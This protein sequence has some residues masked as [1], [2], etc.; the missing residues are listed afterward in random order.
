MS[1]QR[2]IE[3]LLPDGT[4]RNGSGTFLGEHWEVAQREF[5]DVVFD[6]YPS[7]LEWSIIQ[8]SLDSAFSAGWIRLKG[9]D[10][11]E[12]QVWNSECLQRLQLYCMEQRKG[13]GRSFYLDQVSPKK[14]FLIEPGSDLLVLNK[15]SDLCHYPTMTP[16]PEP[17]ILRMNL[18]NHL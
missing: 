18:R 9:F 7:K 17:S 15:P 3:W 5:G 4:I 1:K 6:K 16:T 14:T 13:L 8:K 11:A 12:A 2:L 10:G